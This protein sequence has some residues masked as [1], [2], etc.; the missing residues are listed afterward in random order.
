[1]TLTLIVVYFDWQTFPSILTGEL[2]KKKGE[3]WS[4]WAIVS[5]HVVQMKG[6]MNSDSLNRI[7]TSLK[8][9]YPVLIRKKKRTDKG[10]TGIYSLD[11][12]LIIKEN[13]LSHFHYCLETL[14]L[15]TQFLLMKTFRSLYKLQKVKEIFGV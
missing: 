6:A 11:S 8:S 14:I 7:Y 5:K 15:R 3:R 9:L 12:N 10:I 1:M 4:N 13:V 2:G